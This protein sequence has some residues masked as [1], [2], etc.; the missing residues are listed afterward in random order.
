MEQ[1]ELVEVRGEP[2]CWLFTSGVVYCGET[3]RRS[4][5]F[6]VYYTC[7]VAEG[8]ACPDCAKFLNGKGVRTDRAGKRYA[9]LQCSGC[10]RYYQSYSL[11]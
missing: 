2:G 4:V 10:D 7:K 8:R 6:M 5:D 11:V 3:E 1:P 9:I